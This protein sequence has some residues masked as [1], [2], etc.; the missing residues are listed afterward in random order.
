MTVTLTINLAEGLTGEDVGEFV[1]ESQ[2]LGLTPELT[3]TRALRAAARRIRLR[4]ERGRQF[5]TGANPQQK[6]VM[7]TEIDPTETKQT[8]DQQTTGE[9]ERKR[10][11]R[12]RNGEGAAGTGT[13]HK[14][15]ERHAAPKAAGGD[16]T[17]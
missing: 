7:T 9:T 6:R 2:N 11:R 17:E 14:R 8:H 16:Q 5:L 4:R 1:R 13:R 3:V 15:K 10:T 12:H